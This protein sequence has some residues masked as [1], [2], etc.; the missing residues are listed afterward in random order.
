MFYFVLFLF[1][2]LHLFSILHPLTLLLITSLSNEPPNYLTFLT[3]SFIH[4]NSFSHL[5]SPHI[6]NSK[7]TQHHLIFLVPLLSTLSAL[8]FCCSHAVRHLLPHF[9]A[10]TCII[11]GCLLPI[12]SPIQPL[13][14]PF[15]FT[16]STHTLGSTAPFI[17][18]H[19]TSPPLFLLLSISI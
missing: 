12:P 7:L 15:I 1:S 11:S 14:S 8:L 17:S 13:I 2:L 3:I 4:Y 9:S 6:A 18:T 10:H 16:T 5:H 19:P